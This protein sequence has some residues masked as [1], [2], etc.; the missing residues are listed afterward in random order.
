M[1]SSMGGFVSIVMIFCDRILKHCGSWVPID[2]R[3]ARNDS[4]LMRV[5]I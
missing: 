4:R 5:Q 3:A 1:L 2:A